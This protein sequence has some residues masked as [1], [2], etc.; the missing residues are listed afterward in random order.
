[1]GSARNTQKDAQTHGI[2]TPSCI[3]LV[4]PWRLQSLRVEPSYKITGRT[5]TTTY[6]SKWKNNTQVELLDGRAAF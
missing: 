4:F 6:P 5:K 2:P 3:E 1:M